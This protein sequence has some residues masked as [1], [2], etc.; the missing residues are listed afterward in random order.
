MGITW[1][2]SCHFFP[3]CQVMC[4][5]RWA[6]GGTSHGHQSNFSITQHMLQWKGVIMK[7]LSTCRAAWWLNQTHT[8]GFCDTVEVH[9]QFCCWH[10][11][12]HPRSCMV[13]S[14]CAVVQL[15]LTVVIGISVP[16][17]LFSVQKPTVW[18]T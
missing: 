4:L 17:K 5:P 18:R 9:T 8:L 1:S 6:A 7:H 3:A 2:N 14:S 13:V 15:P 10:P 16:W 11:E 12:P